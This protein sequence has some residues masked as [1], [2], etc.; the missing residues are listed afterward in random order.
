MQTAIDRLSVGKEKEINI[1]DFDGY[2]SLTRFVCPECGEYVSARKNLGFWHLPGKGLDCD[3]RVD[4]Q[5]NL[6]YYERVGL[7][8]YLKRNGAEIT[9]NMM[10]PSLNKHIYDIV[11]DKQITLEIMQDSRIYS[12][13]NV[14]E[15][16]SCNFICEQTSLLKVT[17]VPIADKNYKICISDKRA[18]ETLAEAWS[19][20]SDGFTG[21]GAL[22]TY[23]EKGG[24]KVRKNDTIEPH[25]KYYWVVPSGRY[26]TMNGLICEFVSE[27]YIGKDRFS[28]YVITIE[29]SSEQEFKNL[30]TFFWNRLRLKLLYIKPKII[31]IWPP[32][33]K[34]SEANIPCYM[35]RANKSIFCAVKSDEQSPKI[36]K[37]FNEKYSEVKVYGEENQKWCTLIPNSN[38]QAFTIDRKYLANGLIFSSAVN[39][40]VGKG[41]KMSLFLGDEEITAE[42]NLKLLLPN[43]IQ[44]ISN[45]KLKALFWSSYS[46]EIEE[47]VGSTPTVHELKNK[48]KSIWIFDEQNKQLLRN[49]TFKKPLKAEKIIQDKEIRFLAKKHYLEPTVPI[50]LKYKK[51]AQQLLK[52]LELSPMIS[53]GNIQPTILRY[54]ATGGK[55]DD[56]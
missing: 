1:M 5:S 50:S 9:I 3:R 30:D 46:I 23:S 47:H 52:Y 2:R 17:F 53:T 4:G 10:F 39:G 20:Y 34:T 24:R 28:L 19:Q 38:T 27:F 48:I 36:Y 22:F 8:L 18:E 37:Y 33:A 51:Q 54:I 44:F 41:K 56:E 15:L 40:C 31:P 6:T 45:H 7:S 25:T 16:S 12:S 14:Y 26:S 42:T 43:T 32:V 13:S 35:T 29:H 21:Y 49:I 11:I 55:T